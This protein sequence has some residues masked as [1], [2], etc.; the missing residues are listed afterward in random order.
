MRRAIRRKRREAAA[1]TSPIRGATSRNTS[2]RRQFIQ[3][4]QLVN[5][6]TVRPSR[7]MTSRALLAA[8]VTW[9]TVNV[10]RETRCPR[11]L[12]SRNATGNVSNPSNSK[13]RRRWTTDRE[14]RA[15][16]YCP[17]KPP[18]PRAATVRI[19]ASGRSTRALEVS[20]PSAKARTVSTV[21]PSSSV[22]PTCEIA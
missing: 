15:R 18:R 13:T 4:I 9:A 17:T 16:K 5:A 3:S 8:P 1:T 6:I 12:R 7:A 14:T 10:A 2:V 21:A 20:S 11:A 22:K 19:M